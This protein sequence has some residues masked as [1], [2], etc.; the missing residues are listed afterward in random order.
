MKKTSPLPVKK[1]PFG[2]RSPRGGTSAFSLI[3]LLV[4]VAIMGLLVALLLPAMGGMSGSAARKGAVTIVMTALEQARIASIEQGRDTL[5][6]LWMKNG[7]VGPI[8][9]PD[10]LMI[11]RRNEQDSDWEPLTRWVKL[12]RG[13]LFDGSNNSS[14]ILAAGKL[15]LNG[16]TDSQ[17]DQLPGKPLKSVLGAIRFGSTGAVQAPQA[18][19]S[20]LFIPLVEGQ[21]GSNITIT[22]KRKDDTSREAV[23][24]ARYTGR[25]TLDILSL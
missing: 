20:S 15:A 11:L 23:S 13:V 8:D 2:A 18:A 6:L 19:A 21:R 10:T 5:V 1:N 7:V 14:E 4:V 22:T 12:P 17:L 16:I 3:E 24:V 25:A 9:E